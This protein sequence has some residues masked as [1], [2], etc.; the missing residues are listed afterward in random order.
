MRLYMANIG[1]STI[2]TLAIIILTVLTPSHLTVVM[3]VA[4]VVYGSSVGVGVGSGG[5]WQW[6]Y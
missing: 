1:N 4:V 3:A 6:R 5:V 2:I